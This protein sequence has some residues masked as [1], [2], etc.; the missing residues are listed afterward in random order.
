MKTINGK[1]ILG[2]GV[3]FCLM[4]TGSAKGINQRVARVLSGDILQLAE[5]NVVEEPIT[6]TA[7]VASRSAGGI[8][9]FYSEGDYW[10]PNPENPEGPYIRRDGQTNPD[11][12]VA[13]RH[14]MVR[15]SMIIGN[16]TSAYLLT[17]DKR[18]ID[19]IVNHLSA[20]FI[21]PQTL[22]NPHLLYGQAIKGVVTGRGIGIIDTLQLIEVAQSV[23]LLNNE[24]AL[25][26]DCYEGVRKWFSDYLHWMTTH[27]YGVDEMNAKNNHGTCWAVQAAIFAKLT[28]NQEVMTLCKNRFKEI[29]M[30]TQ[31]AADCSFPQ[32]L[33]RTKPYSYSLF[34]LD[35]MAALCEIL[36][37]PKESLWTFS[38]ADG[39][40][41]RKAV[42]FICPYIKDKGRWPY[43]HDVMYWEEW[44]VAQPALLFAWK[45]FDNEQYW[46]AW[47]PYNHFPTNE[48]VI[49]NLPIR[50][51]LIWLAS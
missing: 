36:S 38:T 21:N 3:L 2:I 6:V 46:Q 40:T 18:F 35:A 48:E 51:P 5:K 50:N 49:R 31:M 25:P 28:G 4:M 12:F 27:P 20:W 34:N 30:P 22:M 37:T 16:L 26:T 45:K 1:R 11:N 23:W 42:D 15:L 29:F 10:W 14:A 24:G 32:E 44:P 8:H 47:A 9:D 19:A 13:H 7:S 41:M 33:A 39:K 43:P 17:K